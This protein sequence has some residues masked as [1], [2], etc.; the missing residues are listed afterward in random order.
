MPSAT[1][2]GAPHDDAEAL[3]LAEVAA[4]EDDHLVGQAQHQR[5]G[6][7]ARFRVGGGIGRVAQPPLAAAVAEALV[8]KGFAGPA[9]GLQH[10]GGE[11]FDV[12][13]EDLAVRIGDEIEIGAGLARAPLDGAHQ[14]RQAAALV[15]L[16]EARHFLVDRVLRL[17]G[18]HAHRQRRH[19]EDE[20]HR[21][22]GEKQEV[23]PGKPC[24]GR[25]K[26][27]RQRHGSAQAFS[28]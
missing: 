8:G 27:G 16:G 26:D 7:V 22:G 1:I 9:F 11:A 10:A 14:Q 3:G 28:M 2:S 25:S 15:G 13:G 19:V 24:R 23:E 20:Q 4:D 17:R 12:A 5:D 18:Q 21:A 6:R